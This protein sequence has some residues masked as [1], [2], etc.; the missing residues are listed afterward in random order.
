MKQLFFG[1]CLDVLKELHQKYPDGIVDLIYIDPPFNS[2]RNYNILYEDLDMKDTKAQKMAFADTWSNLHY[3]DE[4]NEIARIR[5]HLH[6]FLSIINKI[7]ISKSIVAYLTTMSIRIFY[8]KKVLKNTGSF[9]LH[10]DPNMSHY[11]KIVCDLIFGKDNFRNEIIWK[12]TSSHNLIKRYGPIHDVIL[13]YSKSNNYLY[14][15]LKK[16]YSKLQTSKFSLK[17]DF[18]NFKR[19]DLTGSGV[20]MGFSGEKWLRYDPTSKDRHW[21]IPGILKEAF[22]IDS[23]LNTL[24]TLEILNRKGLIL[25]SESPDGLPGY[26]N[27]I[28][29]SMGQS[30][31]DIFYDIPSVKGNENLGYPTQKPETLLERIIKAS[32]NEGDLIADFFCGCGTSI[33]VA[34]R[35]NRDWLGVDISHLAIKLILKR[36]TDPYDDDKKKI[37]IKEIQINGFPKDI[38]SA[39]ELFKIPIKGPIIFQDWV[40]EVLLGGVSNEIKNV[41]GYD[42]Y[43]T[44]AKNEKESGKVLIEVKGGGAGLT[45]LNHFIHTVKTKEAD[46]GVFVCFEEQVTKGMR[47]SAVEEGFYT[48]YKINKIQ[49]ITIEELFEGK[50]IKLPGLAENT[51]FKKNVNG[52]KNNNIDRSFL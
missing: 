20:R 1:D 14:N 32:S 34:N 6:D 25:H 50:E 46:L 42:G 52:K 44:F 26:K 31:Q 49:I 24:E 38:A 36:L 51:T 3:Y 40:I 33:A 8:M 15:N 10:C 9:Y 23:N 18:G 13:Y 48:K 29:L 47:E 41:K 27:Y 28:N 16:D 39:K 7:N 11:L 45:Q 43:L 30:L 5:E 2:K 21:A 12:R 17:D 35:L 19:A 37:L 4:L 22:D